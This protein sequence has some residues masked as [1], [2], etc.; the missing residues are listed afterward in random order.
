ME[1]EF[2][3]YITFTTTTKDGAEVEM[4]VV[5]EFEFERKHYV[6]GAII[7]GETINEDGMYIYRSVISGE[8]FSVEKI[9]SE[10]EYM[11]VAEAYLKI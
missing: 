5:D 1:N 6:V 11:K 4:A 7:E 9:D 3:E 2:Q 10:A 8:E